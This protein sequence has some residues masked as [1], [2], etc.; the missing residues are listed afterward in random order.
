MPPQEG[1]VRLHRHRE[2]EVG[3][4]HAGEEGHEVPASCVR[5]C[6]CVCVCL[7][8]CVRVCVCVCACVRVCARVC[9]GG[10]G[11]R[12]EASAGTGSWTVRLSSGGAAVGKVGWC[13]CAVVVIA[14]VRATRLPL[15][16]S[17]LS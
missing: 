6:V 3:P 4:A 10:C 12:R 15:V 7:R 16:F 2:R 14:C 8:V 13:V 1:E 9:A 17:P 11:H 5:V